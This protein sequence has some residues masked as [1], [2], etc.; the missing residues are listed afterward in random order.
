MKSR[1]LLIATTF[2]GSLLLSM[3]A[4]AQN[5]DGQIQLD[6]AKRESILEFMKTHP[7]PAAYEHCEK[8]TSRTAVVF[9]CVDEDFLIHLLSV[10]KSADPTFKQAFHPFLSGLVADGRDQVKRSLNVFQ[11][12]FDAF[13]D[14]VA[15]KLP[16][17]GSD[18]Y[19]AQEMVILAFGRQVRLLQD[20]LDALDEK[21]SPAAKK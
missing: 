20:D 19:K 10:M 12:E 13:Q 14:R 16:A 2:L 6:P 9:D 15:K 7:Q 1:N 11:K 18:E 17:P 3:T 4:G 21:L 8:V 5:K